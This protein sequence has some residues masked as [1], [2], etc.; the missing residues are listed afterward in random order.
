MKLYSW[1]KLFN[2]SNFHF[3][4]NF[5]QQKNAIIFIVKTISWKLHLKQLNFCTK[6][7]KRTNEIKWGQIKGQMT[8]NI[9]FLEEYDF[10]TCL[11]VNWFTKFERFS[12][13]N[14]NSWM[15]V[16]L[17]HSFWYRIVYPKESSFISTEIVLTLFNVCNVYR[18]CLR[19]F[20]PF[21]IFPSP[22]PYENTQ[23]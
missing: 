4:V 5:H 11:N 15:I 6:K 9:D 22:M 10:Q 2:G 17:K 14:V 18:L 19:H 13:L 20:W 8:Q 12:M 1:S 3:T 7:K 16:W 23:N 21:C